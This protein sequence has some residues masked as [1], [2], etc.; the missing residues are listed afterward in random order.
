MAPSLGYYICCSVSLMAKDSR[1]WIPRSGHVSSFSS[2]YISSTHPSRFF[3]VSAY[4]MCM[5]VVSKRKYTIQGFY[6]R[7]LKR[8]LPEYLFVTGVVLFMIIQR[9]PPI[10]Y[11]QVVTEA[12]S[13]L[14]FLSNWPSMRES[15]YFNVVRKELLTPARSQL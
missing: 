3:V 13:S 7:R 12:I 10:D 8:I 4:L 9:L 1:L 6:Y 15:D 14:C 5:I 11:G 2:L